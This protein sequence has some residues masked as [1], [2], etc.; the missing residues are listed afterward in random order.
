MPASTLKADCPS[1]VISVVQQLY[2]G[3]HRKRAALLKVIKVKVKL[4]VHHNG[5]LLSI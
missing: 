4:T 2:P 3:I 1:I 5:C